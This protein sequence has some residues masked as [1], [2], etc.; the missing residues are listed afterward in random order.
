MA[1][2]AAGLPRPRSHT[3]MPLPARL[4]PEG[5]SWWQIILYAL[6]GNSLIG[7]VLWLAEV[8]DSIYELW[9]TSQAIGFS[10]MSVHVVIAGILGTQRWTITAMVAGVVGGVPLGVGISSVICGP[11]I[12]AEFLG[13]GPAALRYLGFGSVFSLP[14]FAFFKHR[15][16]I[17]AL[18]Q[19]QREAD[20][21]AAEQQ[22]STV[23]AELRRLQAQIEPHF[24]F[25][26]L[27]NV[28][29]LISSN[30]AA[31][32]DLLTQLN[33]HLRAGLKHSR[34]NTTAL[35][36]EFKL[37]ESYLRIHAHRMGP[38]FRWE[39]NLPEDLRNLP[40][41]PMLLQ[42]LVENA[43]RHGIEPKVG[44]GSVT[45][46][47]RRQAG[48]LVLSVVDDG[49]GFQPKPGF[50]GVGLANIRERLTLLFGPDARLDLKENKGPGLTA[51][52]WI[53]PN[54]PAP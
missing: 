4:S 51:E 28:Q 39:L 31:A 22:R 8:H 36:E 16:R 49:V 21:R 54:D 5:L 53:P 52:L 10:I 3:P 20:L 18:E 15:E 43:V 46:S 13:C 38:R 11:E 14:F 26:T 6:V 50:S 2:L 41:P 29:S 48:A 25:N 34:A 42:P 30:P 32:R 24:L 7:L 35:A 17:H 37:L 33:A 47:A 19:V 9:I 44:D 45:L 40:F 27:A 1:T 12:G 23:T